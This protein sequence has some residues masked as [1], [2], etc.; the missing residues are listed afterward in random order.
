MEEDELL[1]LA[2]GETMV[3]LGLSAEPGVCTRAEF[4]LAMLIKL[5]KINSRD[6]SLC[7]NQFSLL[8][9]SG[10]GRLEMEDVVL[11]ADRRRE[12]KAVEAAAAAR[13]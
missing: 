4:T 8:D 3:N 2:G 5:G 11:A 7:F 6:M 12:Q 13:G 9:T 1:A 10:D